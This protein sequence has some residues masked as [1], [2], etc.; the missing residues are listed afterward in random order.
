MPRRGSVRKRVLENDVLYHSVLATRFINSLMKGGKKTIA[1]K[2]FYQ[3]LEKLSPD[4]KEAYE[5]F[6]KAVENATPR[7]EV[8]PRRLGGATYQVPTVVRHDRGEAL[9]IR[10][11]IEAAAEKKGKMMAEKLS[12]E[13]RGASTGQGSAIKKRETAHR[14]SEANKA[15][16]HFRW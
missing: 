10:W 12:E 15:F 1:Q 4:K 8:R 13:F 7:V 14:M 3:S 2:I 11:L 6:R 5:S 9:A 16:A